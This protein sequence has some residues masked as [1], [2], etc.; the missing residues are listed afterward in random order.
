MV[1]GVGGRQGGRRI[2]SLGKR[3]HFDIST[4]SHYSQTSS[5]PFQ[6]PE[7]FSSLL[8]SQFPLP[9]SFPF[10]HPLSPTPFY[11]Y[12]NQILF[13]SFIFPLPTCTS[14]SSTAP[15]CLSFPF[16][17]TL[18]LLSHSLHLLLFSHSPTYLVFHARQTHTLEVHTVVRGVPLFLKT[19]KNSI[20]SFF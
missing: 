3:G 8:L 14:F 18:K 12:L 17:F 15:Q 2:N 6:L 1:R 9:P 5:R 19:K 7:P 10:P 13:L 16:S 4:G 11:S 20:Q